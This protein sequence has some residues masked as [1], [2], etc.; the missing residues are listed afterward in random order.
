MKLRFIRTARDVQT[1]ELTPRFYG[2]AFWDWSRHCYVYY[3]IPLNL[4]VRWAIRISDRIL[5]P[6]RDPKEGWFEK[7]ESLAFQNGLEIGRRQGITEGRESATRDVIKKLSHLNSMSES[8]IEM[9]LQIAEHDAA[10]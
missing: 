10:L 6:F 2:P 1:G 7:R 9:A 4:L 8:Q 5:R 3:P